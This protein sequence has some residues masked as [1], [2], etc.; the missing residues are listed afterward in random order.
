MRWSFRF[1][2][3]FGIDLKVHVTFFLILL[4]GA[5]QGRSTASVAWSSAS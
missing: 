2:R 5:M 1:G 4:L 3:V